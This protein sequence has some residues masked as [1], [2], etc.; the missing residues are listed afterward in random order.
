MV[1]KHASRLSACA[2]GLVRTTFA[3]LPGIATGCAP[4]GDTRALP[5]PPS[6]ASADQALDV[7]ADGQACKPRTCLE[8]S[9]QCGSVPDGCGDT[10]DCGQCPSGQTCGGGGPYQCGTGECTPKT[11]LQLD[12]ACG[13][14]A[15]Q[16][17]DTLDCGLC[18][19]P[20]SCGGSGVENQC[21]CTPATCVERNAECGTTSDGCG[22][23]LPCGT[24]PTGKI[25]GGD[26]P[27]RC[28]DAPCTPKT[29]QTIGASCGAHPDDCDG[30]LSCG[31]CQAPETCGGGGNP[32][33]CGCTPTTCGAQGATCGSLSNGC[34]ITLQCGSCQYGTCQNN[35]CVCTPTTCAAQG[36]NCGTILNGCGGTLSCGTCTPPKQCGAAGTPNVCSCTPA[37]CPPFYTNSF[38]AGTDFPSAWIAWHNC[39]AD[40]TWSIS[41]E[42]Y[43][44]P[45][46]GSQNLRFHTT[47]F[48]APCDYPGGYAQGPAWTVVPGRTYRVESWSRNGGSQTGLA[49]LFFNAGG[50]NTLY[51][52]VVFPG[53]AWEY[54]ADP[55][56]SAVAPAGATYVQVR[57]FLRAPSSYLDFDLLAVYEEP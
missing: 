32:V 19:P 31:S 16:C 53:D 6:D 40:T 46:G 10:V 50:T 17:G 33:S 54:K 27:N 56:L 2:L 12:A 28:G 15:D 36:A 57:V 39:A 51:T 25:C 45:S 43:P 35:Q 7:T 14:A 30:V 49:L 21:G 24:C 22:G 41:V 20:D 18:T 37:L 1:E 11:C 5:P 47:A 9:A 52:E 48:T 4:E 26:A 34:G 55:A 42:P 44:A 23:V 38:E 29:C 8:L 13:L 3:L